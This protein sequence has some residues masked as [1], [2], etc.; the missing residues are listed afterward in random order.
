ME[1]LIKKN[2]ENDR[3]PA[4][5]FPLPFLLLFFY[6]GPP[7]ATLDGE[8]SMKPETSGRQ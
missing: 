6:V 2:S 7:A 3:P 1:W 8:I 5:S 4:Y